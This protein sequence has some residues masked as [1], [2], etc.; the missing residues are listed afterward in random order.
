VYK[1]VEPSKIKEQARQ[2][3]KEITGGLEDL[4]DNFESDF[5]K[6]LKAKSSA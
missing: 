5:T 3:V 6:H 2:K 4:I 1:A